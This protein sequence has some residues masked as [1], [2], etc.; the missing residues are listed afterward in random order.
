MPKF[1]TTIVST[2]LHISD[3]TSSQ[4][5]NTTNHTSTL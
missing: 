4:N 2:L 5:L 3:S 1:F